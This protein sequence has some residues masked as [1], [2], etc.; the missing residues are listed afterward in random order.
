VR[1]WLFVLVEERR[2]LNPMYYDALYLSFSNDLGKQ[3]VS[4]RPGPQNG[5]SKDQGCHGSGVPPADTG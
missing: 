1:S 2:A 5:V 4:P 3:G